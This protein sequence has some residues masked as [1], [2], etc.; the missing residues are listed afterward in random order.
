LNGNVKMMDIFGKPH[1]LRFYVV[2]DAQFAKTSTKRRLE[3]C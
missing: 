2:Q 3:I 1:L